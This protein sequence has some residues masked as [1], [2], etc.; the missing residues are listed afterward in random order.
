M[1]IFAV[2]ARS[3]AEISRGGPNAPPPPPSFSSYQNSPVFLGLRLDVNIKT[4]I[5]FLDF[6]E[7]TTSGGEIWRRPQEIDRIQERWRWK[8]SKG[9]SFLLLQWCWP[10]HST[11]LI[12]CTTWVLTNLNLMTPLRTNFLVREYCICGYF[13]G[14]FI[15]VSQTSRKFPLQF[16]SIIVLVMKTSQN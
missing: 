14:G 3:T 15:F 10:T 8:A 12:T 16:L 9:D 11:D 6:R 13:H 4:T 1:Q 2:S 7:Y 5:D